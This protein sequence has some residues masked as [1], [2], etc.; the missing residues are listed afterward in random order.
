MELEVNLKDIFRN[1][2]QYGTIGDLRRIFYGEL[3][4]SST[5]N[6]GVYKGISYGVSGEKKYE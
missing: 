6:E 5:G 3:D 1:P 4:K 2:E